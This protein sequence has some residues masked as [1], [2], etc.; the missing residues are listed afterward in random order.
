MI[1]SLFISISSL[2]ILPKL[3]EFPCIVGIGVCIA[4][5]KQNCLL[6]DGTS[7]FMKS[8]FVKRFSFFNEC[9]SLACISLGY[10]NVELNR[11]FISVASLFIASKLIERPTLFHIYGSVAGIKENRLFINR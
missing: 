7:L 5:I 9:L 11:L 2:F 3:V 10:A 8:K 1:N 6:I 4:R